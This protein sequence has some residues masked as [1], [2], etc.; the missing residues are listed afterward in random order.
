MLGK[1][2]MLGKGAFSLAGGP[3][4][5]GLMALTT[6]PMLLGMGA[7][8][9]EDMNKSLSAFGQQAI[10]TSD[11]I[12]M[13]FRNFANIQ[14]RTG[15][16]MSEQLGLSSTFRAGGSM[17]PAQDSAAFADTA[18][19]LRAG[20]ATYQ[21][22]S[23][24]MV[25]ATQLGLNP[26]SLGAMSA[27]DLNQ[28]LV[29]A[30][31]SMEKSQRN[32]DRTFGWLAAIVG[33][34]MAGNIIRQSQL[35]DRR[36]EEGL[37]RASLMEQWTDEE[38]GYFQKSSRMAERRQELK[39]ITADQKDIWKLEKQAWRERYKEKPGMAEARQ[40]Y[41]E[42]WREGSRAVTIALDP[43]RKVWQD[44]IES[45]VGDGSKFGES[46]TKIAKL[47]G[48]RFGDAVAFLIATVMAMSTPFVLLGEAIYG[49]IKAIV[50]ASNLEW[51]KAKDA[52]GGIGTGTKVLSEGSLDIYQRLFSEEYNSG[53]AARLKVLEEYGPS[54]QSH[55]GPN[56]INEPRQIQTPVWVEVEMKGDAAQWLTTTQQQ[57]GRTGRAPT[58]LP[59]QGGP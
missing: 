36:Y 34:D 42:A 50:H 35:S 15:S 9:T 3:I 48:S 40:Q 26:M 23:S 18:R 11:D 8:K 27:S 13:A 21:P 57:A 29:A 31:R 43:V 45:I 6:L 19:G 20:F 46:L 55:L 32:S 24:A 37:A 10:K 49:V 39:G 52:L 17:N 53:P 2:A 33:G 56:A 14:A 51:N 22:N 12:A 54:L 16:S 38:T 30:V 28:S 58:V 7:K 59:A 25:G 41:G 47:L 1:A 4:G 44:F 5:V